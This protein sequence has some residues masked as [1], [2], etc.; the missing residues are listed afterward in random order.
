[1]RKGSALETEDWGRLVHCVCGGD[2]SGGIEQRFSRNLDWP[3]HIGN[4]PSDS[5][6]LGMRKV[7]GKRER[8]F[9]GKLSNRLKV[10]DPRC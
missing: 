10:G 7:V 6:G 3:L 8:A 5:H 1:M 2:V 4:A 9:Q